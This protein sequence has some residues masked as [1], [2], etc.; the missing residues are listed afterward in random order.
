MKRKLRYAFL[1]LAV[2][3]LAGVAVLAAGSYGTQEDPLITKSYLDGVVQPRLESQLQSELKDAINEIRGGGNGEFELVTLSDG[4]S[5]VCEVGTEI[6]PRLGTLKAV[7]A[8]APALIDTS[9]GSSLS[10][11]A[12]LTANHLYLVSI[13]GNGVSAGADGAKLLVSGV[14][15]L[16]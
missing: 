14:Y 9:T 6:L 11:G 13:Q 2:L 3:V 8:S 16:E 15:T 1:A 7:G 10:A 4:Q 12:A 5:L